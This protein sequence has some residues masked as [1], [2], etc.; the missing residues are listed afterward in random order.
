MKT[1]K[2]L[3][4]V[5][6]ALTVELGGVPPAPA[7]ALVSVLLFVGGYVV[8]ARWVFRVFAGR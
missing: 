4:L 7:M 3:L 1:A 5:L 6:L 8:N 2:T